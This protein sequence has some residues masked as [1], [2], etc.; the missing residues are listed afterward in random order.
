MNDFRS[1]QATLEAVWTRLV[2]APTNPASPARLITLATIGLSGNA[3][4][5]MIVL[6]ASNRE[7]GEITAY[8]NAASS[9]TAEL[10]HD[11]RAALLFWDPEIR[12]QVRLSTEISQRQGHDEEWQALSDSDRVLYAHTPLPGEVLASPDAVA[13]SPD[14]ALFTVLTARIDRIETLHL[15][16]VRHRRAVFRR[17]NRFAGQWIAP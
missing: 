10:A 12:L 13:P 7:R 9:K 15:G 3:E 6:R 16:R 5:R 14:S 1:L 4:A 17:E 8:T 2:D 11:P